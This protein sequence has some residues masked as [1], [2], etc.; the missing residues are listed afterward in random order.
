MWWSRGE[1]NSG[2]DTVS[3]HRYTS[4]RDVLRSACQTSIATSGIRSFINLETGSERNTPF[5]ACSRRFTGKYRQTSRET[6]PAYLSSEGV[7][8]SVNYFS[9]FRVLSD[10]GDHCLRH[11]SAIPVETSR[12]RIDYKSSIFFENWQA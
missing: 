6:S 9:S 1:S 2:P 7:I 3:P 8:I 12:P 11:G 5:P 4:F 10:C